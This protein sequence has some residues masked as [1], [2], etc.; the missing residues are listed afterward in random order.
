MNN[1]ATVKRLI[2]QLSYEVDNEEM[3]PD[4]EN[5][6]NENW[7]N[8]K[9]DYHNKAD[10]IVHLAR[11]KRKTARLTCGKYEKA[12]L[13][14]M[15]RLCRFS[16]NKEIVDMVNR[17]MILCGY[18][19]YKRK[20][21]RFIQLLEN[22]KKNLKRKDPEKYKELFQSVKTNKHISINNSPEIKSCL[23]CTLCDCC[24]NDYSSL[25]ESTSNQ[26][27]LPQDETKEETVDQ[28]NPLGI[29]DEIADSIIQNSFTY[30]DDYYY[31]DDILI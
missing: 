27:E 9:E 4:V 13:L 30:N 24:G 1:K 7:D 10:R 3:L 5:Y 29:N 28:N 23:T 8:F 16:T 26:I 12:L 11:K 25:Q 17:I 2:R 22:Y 19:S 20:K 6:I 14:L 31:Y 18:P 21:A 15:G